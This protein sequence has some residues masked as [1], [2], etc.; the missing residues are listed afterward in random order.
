MRAQTRNPK[1]GF[2]LHPFRHPSS[3][4]TSFIFHPSGFTII[5]LL[6]VIAIIAILAGLL[7]PVMGLARNAAQSA[8]CK[9]NLHQLGI[10]MALYV[11]CNDDRC[12]PISNDGGKYSFWFGRRPALYG[13]P[14]FQNF[15]RTQG[16]LYPY[17][18]VTRAVEQC[19]SFDARYRAEDGKLVGYAYN[20]ALFKTS[21]SGLSE[22]VLCSR[23]RNPSGMVVFIDGG[24]ISN[25][26]PPFYTPAGCVEENYYLML[27]ESAPPSSMDMPSVHYRHNGSAN[28]LFADWH[29]EELLP[30]K[31]DPGGDGRV[32][33]LCHS[34]E[35]SK[36]YDP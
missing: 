30:Y 7:L 28:C 9:S 23:I 34:N 26:K 29:V 24:R 19:P 25:G 27:P 3:F 11:N 36:Y 16:Y 32:G 4:R 20:A 2:I 10:A 17:L 35:K 33:Y 12:M 31:L 18:R 21:T 14:G 8:A 5:E 15:D 13:Q 22:H 1:S 6:V